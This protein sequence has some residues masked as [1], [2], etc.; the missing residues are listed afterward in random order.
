MPSEPAES[1]FK[2]KVRT[3]AYPTH[4]SGGLVWTYMGPRET[5]PAFRT[6]VSDALPRE[7]WQ[8]MKVMGLCNWVQGLEGNIDTAHISWLHRPPRVRDFHRTMTDE[9]GYPS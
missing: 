2:N 6:S 5:M 3:T 7:Q 9:P 8:A 1:N 4:E